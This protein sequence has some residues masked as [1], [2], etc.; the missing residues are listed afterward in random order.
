MDWSNVFS[1]A[2]TQGIGIQAVIFCLAAIG[3]NVQFGYTGLLNFGQSGFLAVAAYGLG[4]SI[5]YAGWSLWVGILVGIAAAVLL[6]LLLGIPT[7]RLR[8]DYL[9]IVTIAAAEI[10]RLTFRSV[11]FDPVFGGSDGIN[12]F[13][14]DFYT[15]NPY[16]GPVKIGPAEFSQND[17]W[18]VTIGWILVVILS[19]L[20]FLL[21]RSP[22]GRV[23]KAIREDEDAVRS[24]GKSVYS[25]KLQS[26]II[27][28]V[29][30]CFGG[31]IAAIAL[32]SIQ[33]DYYSTDLTFFAYAVLILGGAARVLGPI[34]GS[35][36]F[37]FMLVFIDGALANAVSSGAIDFIRSDQVG[38]IRYWILGIAL[39]LLMIYRPQGILGDKKELSL[40]AR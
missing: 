24:L 37:W 21:M 19:I 5:A 18:I 32:Q 10:L 30:G 28:G 33:P 8:A 17:M 27:G 12:R 15:Y 38:Q 39:M 2:L 26:L 35:V 29:M 7:L 31:F 16:S 13:A 34:V 36:V 4:V 25:Y 9:A 1:Q 20:V 14:D 22:W 6:A 11:T 23:I 3:L 40:D